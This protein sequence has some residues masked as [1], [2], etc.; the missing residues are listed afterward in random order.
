MRVKTSDS[1][2]LLAQVDEA[3]YRDL[4]EEAP[5]GYLSVSG[6]GRILSTN[7]RAAQMIGHTEDEV[8]GR[9]IFDFFADTSAARGPALNLLSRFLAG[10]EFSGLEVAVCR[11]DS[12]PL[13]ISLWM[14]PIRG[15]D[16]RVQASRAIWVDITDRVFAA[17]ERARLHQQNLYLQDELKATHNFE[18][19]I[20]KSP[21]LCA[22][23][24]DVR[25]VAPTDASVL[26][27]G[28]TGTGKE[29]FARAI[30]SASKRA[31]KAFIIRAERTRNLKLHACVTDRF[32][33]RAFS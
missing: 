30:H 20:G 14:K 31:D 3:R 9:C 26:I 27:T 25:R 19:I 16:G 7:H 10:D 2:R 13:W 5:V 24:D 17:A 6:E 1:E 33:M 4:Y 22:V 21:A 8:N 32:A 23:L 12:R 15:V 29:L 11:A 28:E 18:A